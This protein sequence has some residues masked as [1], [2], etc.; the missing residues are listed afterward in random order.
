MSD[1]DIEV[2]YPKQGTFVK[3]YLENGKTES[4][5]TRS[6]KYELLPTGK[7]FVNCVIVP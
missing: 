7:I 6:I 4:Y 2:K 3:L 5:E 1:K